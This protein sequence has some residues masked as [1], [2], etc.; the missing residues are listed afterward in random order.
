MPPLIFVVTVKAN[1]LRGCATA[2]RRSKCS[3]WAT[4][5]VDVNLETFYMLL[6]RRQV[7][8]ATPVKPNRLRFVQQ[9]QLELAS[10]YHA[11][12]SSNHALAMDHQTGT[13]HRQ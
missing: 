11:C 6:H 2:N 7:G 9:N 4:Y 1:A 13:K 5:K 3:L 12:D 8:F 10:W